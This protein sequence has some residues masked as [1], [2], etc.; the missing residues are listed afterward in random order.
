MSASND[1]KMFGL[2]PRNP[3]KVDFYITMVACLAADAYIGT[4]S[5]PIHYVTIVI[6]AIFGI[7]GL[8]RLGYHPETQPT[9]RRNASDNPAWPHASPPAR[10][11]PTPPAGPNP[12][13][14]SP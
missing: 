14:P 7:E 11:P 8:L 2:I 4:P 12:S 6:G 10:R 3:P 13:A 5:E 1:E 9:P